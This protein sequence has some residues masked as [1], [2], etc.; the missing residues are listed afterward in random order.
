MRHLVLAVFVSL[1]GFIEGPGKQLVPPTWSDDMQRHWSDHNI[2][3]AGA[4]L[5]GRICYEGMASFWPVAA[6]DK[7]SPHYDLAQQMARLPKMVFSKTLKNPTWANT[8]VL[9]GDLS[10]EIG[11]LKRQD[12]KDLMLFGG[13]AIASH[14]MKLGL[15][16]EYRIMIIPTIL[17]GGTPLF[18]GGYGR[19]KL[20]LIDSKTM[21]TGSVILSY[22]PDAGAK[23]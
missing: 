8:T 11:K 17:G 3:R 16:D 20:E 7:A 23:I 14:L 13:A 10:D 5:Y 22:R 9:G 19:T 1:D 15:I 6:A 4:L 18:S 2:A 21:D 12:G